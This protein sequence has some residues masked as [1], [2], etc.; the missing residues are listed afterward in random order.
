MEILYN[1]AKDFFNKKFFKTSFFYAVFL[2][3][4]FTLAGMMLRSGVLSGLDAYLRDA[5]LSLRG[6]TL[7]HLMILTTYLSDKVIVLP[8]ALLT[9]IY[10]LYRKK[11]DFL[12]GLLTSSFVV[13]LVVVLAKLF[14]ARLR[15]PFSEA[16]L[17]ENDFSFPSGH[18]ARAVAFYGILAYFVFVSTRNKI[19]KFLAIFVGLAMIFSISFSR[20]YL[21]VH[22][23]SDVFGSLI[24]SG[25]WLCLLIYLCE[26]KR[27]MRIQ[28][29]M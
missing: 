12:F 2:A 11:Y 19:E 28:M 16:L 7:N 15:P 20:V 9:S 25:V 29:M 8:V 10:F 22:W 6:E 3:V 4:F 23:P 26:I 21:G 17:F 24:F 14:F 1:L 27:K 18:T 5:V 13:S